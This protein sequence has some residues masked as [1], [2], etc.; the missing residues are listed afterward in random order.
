MKCILAYHS[1]LRG[2]LGPAGSVW[3]PAL[4]ANRRGYW[5]VARTPIRAPSATQ[6]AR[7]PMNNLGWI[8][9]MAAALFFLLGVSA[10]LGAGEGFDF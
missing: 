2:G 10:L 1:A 9:L 4:L 7:V 5:L 6:S 8:H 3:S